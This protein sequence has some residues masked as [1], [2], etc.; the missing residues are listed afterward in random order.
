MIPAAGNVFP[1]RNENAIGLSSRLAPLAIECFA[2]SKLT[3]RY[4]NNQSSYL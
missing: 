4:A 2:E 3:C 1:L